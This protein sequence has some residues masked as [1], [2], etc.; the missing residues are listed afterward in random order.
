M[1]IATAS[2]NMRAAGAARAAVSTLVMYDWTALDKRGKRMKGEMQAK[3][4][5]LVKAELRR[6]GMN[7][8]TV[9]ERSK[10]LFGASGK[11]VKPQ[12]VAIFSRQIATMMASG[13]PMVQAF[14]IIA[15]GQKNVRFKNMLIDVKTD[16]EGGAALHEALGRYPVQFDELYRNLVHAGESAGVLDTVLDTVATYKERMEGIKK[17]I[18][19]ALF[20]PIMVLVVALLVS[21]IL[22]LFVVPVFQQTFAEAKAELPAPTQFVVSASQFMQSYWWLVI[23]MI[24]GSIAAIIFAKNRSEKFAHFLDRLSLKIPVIGDLLH[25]SAIARFSRTLGVTFHAGVPLVEA[26]D[27]VAGATGSVVYG[28]AV[29]QMRDDIAVGHQLQLSMRQVN[30]FPNMVVQMTAIGEESGSLDSMLFK[31]AEFYEEEVNTAVDTLSSLLE[32][33]IMVI[34]GVLVGGMVIS[35]YL[36]IFKLAGT[37]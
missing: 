19:K 31:V 34:L 17:K 9:R 10:P 8:Q 13:V 27:A 14:D 24:V 35:L 23:G 6:Q 25:K 1:A 7:P 20:Y 33:F 15:N 4:A 11:K 29:K 30:L 3:N 32:P 21:M 37:V 22:L 5:S 18:K 26:L 2:K 16:I 12:D 28:E 36:P